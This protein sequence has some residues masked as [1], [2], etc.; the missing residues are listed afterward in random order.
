MAIL[1]AR[2][3]PLLPKRAVEHGLPQFLVHV[4]V[5]VAEPKAKFGTTPDLRPRP[6]YVRLEVFG[7]RP[8]GI[9]LREQ[10]H[11]SEKVGLLG[12]GRSFWVGRSDRM[13]DGP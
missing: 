2:P 9:E 7:A 8:A 11:E 6:R 1:P 10:V 3:P 4:V 13:E 5:R 12:C